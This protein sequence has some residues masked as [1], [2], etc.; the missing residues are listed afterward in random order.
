MLM[1]GGKCTLTL[2]GV[3]RVPPP[4]VQRASATHCTQGWAGPSTGLG[5]LK[6]QQQQQQQQ[7]QP[8]ASPIR[9]Q[10]QPLVQSIAIL[11]CPLSLP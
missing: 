4:G 9:I 11:S 7:Q 5:A 6:Q 3:P 10:T 1:G 8:I 2:G